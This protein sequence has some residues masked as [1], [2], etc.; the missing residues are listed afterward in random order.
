MMDTGFI[1]MTIGILQFTVIP[2]FADL[3]RTHAA[4]PDWPGHARNHL[5]TQVLTT[6]SLGILA[7]YF[8]WSGR[9]ER[10]LGICLAMMAAASA[11]L[12][13]FA[14]ALASPLFGGQLMPTREGL[15]RIRFARIEGNLMNFGSAFL[16]IVAGRLMLI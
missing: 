8:L 2:L 9:L 1:L 5:V 4:N 3:N 16:M 10:E 13:F 14:S 11:L 12:P 6:S 7:L 15:G